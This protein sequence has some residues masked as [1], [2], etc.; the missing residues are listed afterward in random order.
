M[1]GYT[2]PFCS[3]I[4]ALSS[5]T[6][7]I[8]K[9]SFSYGAYRSTMGTAIAVV[10]HKCPNCN[11]VSITAEG[12]SPDL[13]GLFMRIYPESK[14]N[15]IDYP[16][17][18]PLQIRTD[19]EEAAMIADLSP[20]ASATIAR[21]CLQGMIHDYWGINKGNLAKEIIA[22]EEMIPADQWKVIDSVRRIGNIGAHM[23]KDI[24]LIIEIDKDEAKKL[25]KLI[26]LLIKIW[27]I[28]RHEREQLF[29][30]ILAIDSKK[31]E[32]K[33]LVEPAI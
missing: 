26:E 15:I 22:L 23:E 29:E 25:L 6:Q 14:P 7:S 10:F 19:Y 30:D 33:N 12:V 11:K 32:Q 3:Q 4:M 27:Y 17:Y 31:Q 13:A 9:L 5:D 2:C 8:E 18:I 20:K 16:D 21:R 28:D 1:A 24:N